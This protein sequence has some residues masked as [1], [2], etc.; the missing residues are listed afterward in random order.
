M[1]RANR[2]MQPGLVYHLTHRCHDRSFLFRFARDR[3]EY[4][5]R[6]RISSADFGV[7]ILNYSVTSN[8]EH[9]LAFESHAGAISGMMHDVQGEFAV[10]YNRRKCRTGSFWEDRYHCTMVEDG[11][12]LL[13]CLLYIDMNMVRAG[14]VSHP[15]EWPWCG[16]HEIMGEKTRNRLL[17]FKKLLEIMGLGAEQLRLLYTTEL[18]R[19]IQQKRFQ[20]EAQW[21]ESIA[22]GSECYVR[23]VSRG[24]LGR[25]RLKIERL[26]KGA[27][28]VRESVAQYWQNLPFVLKKGAKSLS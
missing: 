10:Y 20:R 26:D 8:H 16:Y 13:N 9:T 25:H 23:R 15:R 12:H 21:T 24:V 3:S 22:V 14:V 27:W 11:Q 19:C 7:S 18:E 28:A 17:D 1:P 2:I 4:C 5:K 6:L